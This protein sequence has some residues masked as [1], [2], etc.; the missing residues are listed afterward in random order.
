MSSGPT[1]RHVVAGGLDHRVFEWDGGGDT[2]VLLLHGLADSGATWATVVPH[3]PAGLHVVAPDLRGHGGTGHVGA[4]GYYFFPDYVRDL[5]DLVDALERE[6]LV[7][8]G[9]SMGG[10]VSALFTGA[11]P[12][13]VERL[14]L[15][16]GLGPPEEDPA[17]APRR[18]RRWIR[19]VQ[20]VQRGRRGPGPIADLADAAR[21]LRRR[22]PGLDEQASLELARWLTVEGDDGLR[23]SADPLHRTRTPLIFQLHRWAPFLDAITCPVLTISGGRSWY[24]WPELEARYALLADRRHLELEGATHAVHADAPEALGAAIGRFIEGE[25]P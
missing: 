21:K 14:V 20:Q 16:E 22:A 23:W 25:E 2:T 4:G 13:E 7:L 17:E 15:V 8:V 19:E 10:G 6:R 3:L 1:I 12:D 5:R 24:R 11:W 9:H 18:L